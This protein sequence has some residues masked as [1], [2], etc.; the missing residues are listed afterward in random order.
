[1]RGLETQQLH[2]QVAFASKKSGV[3]PLGIEKLQFQIFPELIQVQEFTLD[4]AGIW[5]FT[6]T[7]QERHFVRLPRS[8]EEVTE[9]VK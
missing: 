1:M 3:K 8:M 9:R 2:L 5:D 6:T 7:T 4:K